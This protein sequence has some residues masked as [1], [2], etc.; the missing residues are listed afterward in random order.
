MIANGNLWPE[1]APFL[2]VYRQIY[3]GQISFGLLA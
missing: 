3:R 1:S 2:Y